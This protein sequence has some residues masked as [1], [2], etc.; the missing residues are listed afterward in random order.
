MT[1]KDLKVIEVASVDPTLPSDWRRDIRALIVE[2]RKLRRER[3]E[4]H[5]LADRHERDCDEYR[6]KWSKATLEV[7]RLR[8][9]IAIVEFNG[10]DSEHCP[11]CAAWRKG[12]HRDEP[13][14]PDCPAFTPSGEVK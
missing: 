1:E 11:W 3:D 12:S 2:A 4:W 14:K 7:R 5:G 9:T 6:E 10:D 8:E 13:H